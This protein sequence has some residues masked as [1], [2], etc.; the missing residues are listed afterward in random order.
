MPP[1]LFFGILT[2][3]VLIIGSYADLK[4]REVP[5]W[6]NYGLIASA[7][8]ARVIWSA[9]YSDWSYIVEGGLGLA[10]GVALAYAMFYAGQW[11]GGDAK[12]MMGLGAIIGLPFQA[13]SF[14]LGFVLNI[15]LVGAVYALGW[16]IALVARNRKDF[17]KELKRMLGRRNIIRARKMI[18][19]S[20]AALLVVA[21]FAGDSAMR[22]MLFSLVLLYAAAFYLW[23]FVRVIEKSCMLKRVP[24]E[25]LT[26][27]DWIAKDIV[28]GGKRITG[29]KD[30][31]VSR[32][33]IKELK[34]LKKQ[35]K[36]DRVLIKEGIPFVPSFLI[37]FIVTWLWGNLFLLF[38]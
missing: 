28:V 35:K 5:D 19:V 25:K 4:T 6:L 31:G 2:V 10:A 3:A 37:A 15:L 20:A 38:I 24:P 7:I 21:L 33:Q 17:A 12:M 9:S 8:G 11:G 36:I 22:L 32:E 16:S 13:D 29:P 18:I 34:K 27:G 14:L 26:E 30:L 23:V 1:E